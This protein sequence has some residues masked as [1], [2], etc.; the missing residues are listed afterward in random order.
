M[1]AYI[2]VLCKEGHPWIRYSTAAAS[3]ITTAAMYNPILP[4]ILP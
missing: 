3:I 1:K 4:P 2:P